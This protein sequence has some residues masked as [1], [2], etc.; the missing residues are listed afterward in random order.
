MGWDVIEDM[1]VHPSLGCQGTDRQGE[2]L[3]D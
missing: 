3:K 2:S 1:V